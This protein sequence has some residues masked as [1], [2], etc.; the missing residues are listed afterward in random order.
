[1]AALRRVD[2]TW[3]G[4]QGAPYFTQMFFSWQAGAANS[5]VTALSAFFNGIRGFWITGLTA[6]LDPAQTVVESST[7]FPTGVE[8]A[9]TA[10]VFNGGGSGPAH[11]PATQGL[12]RLQ[13]NMYNG[14]RRLTG[15]MYLPGMITLSGSLVP[16]S[17]F[18]TGVNNFAAGLITG[19]AGSGQWG[20]YSRT[21]KAF[22]NVSSATCWDQWA[23]MRSRRDS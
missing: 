6:T 13:T 11:P 8:T 4:L 2:V 12:L 20:V 1:M 17:S 14:A 5:T 3:T 16:G 22:A 23:V 10:G 9:T 15:R 21:H 7:G 18:T 19:T